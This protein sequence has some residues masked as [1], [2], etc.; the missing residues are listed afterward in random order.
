M[1]SPSSTP[2]KR[3]DVGDV[4]LSDDKLVVYDDMNGEVIL[5]EHGWA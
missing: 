5:M 4:A 2:R 1:P 3:W